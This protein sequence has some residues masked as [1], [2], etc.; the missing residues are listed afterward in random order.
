MRIMDLISQLDSDTSSCRISAKR[1]RNFFKG[2]G[3]GYFK[4]YPKAILMQF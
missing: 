2:N 1:E 3:T 4:N